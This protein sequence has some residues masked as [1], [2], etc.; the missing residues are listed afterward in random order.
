MWITSDRIQ[1]HFL[2][3]VGLF[4]ASL[5]SLC[6]HSS[7]KYSAVA[8]RSP[9]HWSAYCKRILKERNKMR[10]NAQDGRK[11]RGH[12]A[13]VW[14]ESYNKKQ[15]TTYDTKNSDQRQTCRLQLFNCV[16]WIIRKVRKGK[17]TIM[18]AI[19]SVSRHCEY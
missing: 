1:M 9:L 15:Q 2:A 18:N 4:L 19:N 14:I 7:F 11:K 17:E 16:K 5:R 3:N 12:A 6:F 13:I 8:M 10:Q